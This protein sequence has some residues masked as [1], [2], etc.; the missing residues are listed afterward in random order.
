[1][2]ATQIENKADGYTIGTAS[3]QK[4]GFF[5]ATPVDQPGATEKLNEALSTLGLR[6]TGA[7]APLDS[8]TITLAEAANIVVGTTTGTKIGTATSQK[9]GFY[10]ATPVIQPA[11]AGQGAVAAPTAYS[12]HASGAVPVVSNAATDLDTTAAALATLVTEV[13]NLRTLVDAMRTAL[14]DTGVMKGA[15]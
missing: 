15:A 10:N 3:T 5:G 1:M 7:A 11:A 13:T 4:V 14:V 6:A 12:A 2:A 9:L 8:G